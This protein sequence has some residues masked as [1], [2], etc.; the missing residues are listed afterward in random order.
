MFNSPLRPIAERFLGDYTKL[1]RAG[2]AEYTKLLV[3]GLV[4][5]MRLWALCIDFSAI[6]KQ[7]RR[8]CSER[9]ALKS[10]KYA[11]RF[12]RLLNAKPELDSKMRRSES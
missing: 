11:S 4:L 6:G 7:T 12:L 10:G 8:D 9:R 5:T 3:L 2:A 1:L